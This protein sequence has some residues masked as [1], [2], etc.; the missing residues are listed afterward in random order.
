MLINPN[1]ARGR[2]GGFA[3]ARRRIGLQGTGKIVWRDVENSCLMS[4][5]TKTPEKKKKKK[6]GPPGGGKP[7]APNPR[8]NPLIFKGGPPT[9]GGKPPPFLFPLFR[10]GV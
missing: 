5:L 6:R 8:G 10:G 3:S 9:P 1:T 7:R 2:R 4:Y